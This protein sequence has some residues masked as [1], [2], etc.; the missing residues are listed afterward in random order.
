[1]RKLRVKTGLLTVACA[2]QLA[3]GS[4]ASADE[5]P[6]PVVTRL[7]KNLSVLESEWMESV[8]KRDAAALEKVLADDFEMRT[9]AA[10]GMP[11][12][13]SEWIAQS[14]K[15]APFASRTEQMAVH[16]FGNL[17][18]ASFIWKLDAPKSSGFARQLF[19]VDT[20]EQVDGNWRVK[21]RYIGPV[22]TANT[23]IPGAATG[24]IIKKKY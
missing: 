2:L 21:V 19:V 23:P 9:A 15:Q 11:T 8:R 24:A 14:M 1:M 12:A 5:M 6:V 10:P 17:A 4:H 7:V 16:D 20:W 22:A 3:S 18:V 13:R